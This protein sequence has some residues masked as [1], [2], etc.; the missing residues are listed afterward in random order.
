[1]YQDSKMKNII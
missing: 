1:M